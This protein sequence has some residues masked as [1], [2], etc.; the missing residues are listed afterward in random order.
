MTNDLE[1]NM[2]AG[3]W[4][5]NIYRNVNN[6]WSLINEG[7]DVAFIWGIEVTEFGYIFVATEKGIYVNEGDDEWTLV[8]LEEYDVR[9]IVFDSNGYL[10]AGT[11]GGG[12]FKSED[13]GTSW[14]E[15]NDGLVNLAINSLAVTS[16]D[17]L[18]AATFGT[19]IAKYEGTS[20]IQL[21]NS[22]AVVWTLAVSSD[23][24]VYAGTYGDGLH[25]SGDNGTTWTK[26]SN[27]PAVYIYSLLFDASDNLYVSSW[28]A[29]VYVAAS[30]SSG[31]PSASFQSV[32][33]GG[34]GVSSVFV[35]PDNST[36]YAGTKDGQ[37][38]EY[39][40]NATDVE[41]VNE[42][43]AEYA[44]EQ[45]YPNPFNPTTNIKFSVVDAGRYTLKIYNILGEEVA[46]L[47][48]EQLNPGNYTAMFEASRLSSGIYIYQLS[49]S[50][51]NIV[52]K[53]MLLK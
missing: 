38:F 22:Y 45:N 9:D 5:G 29:G 30:A 31:T 27:L 24:V 51:V 37:I 41:D 20:W 33:L 39:N 1:G 3:T 2:I 35:D 16:D 43:P 4:G 10:Y 49:G 47:I 14:T 26:A 17:V 40:A 7:M 53:M 19:G 52:K 44:L 15:I 6:E 46:T 28:T 13:N 48:N 18:F 12:V 25:S 36:L 21:E 23:D 32:G 50:N 34:A 8:G 42:L 11:W